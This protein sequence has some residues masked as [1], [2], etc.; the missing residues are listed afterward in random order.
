[1]NSVREEAARIK[2]QM[3]EDK[4][5]D[6]PIARGG[7]SAR[8]FSDMHRK[9][10][11]KMPSIGA[12]PRTA[13]ATYGQHHAHGA[14]NDG[15][16]AA[17]SPRKPLVMTHGNQAQ[18]TSTKSTSRKEDKGAWSATTSDDGSVRTALKRKLPAAL[19]DGDVSKRRRQDADTPQMPMSA[20]PKSRYLPSVI[21]TPTQASLARS[22]FPMKKMGSPDRAIS[23]ARV[24]SAM[25]SIL[26]RPLF[27]FSDDPHKLAAGT[28]LPLENQPLPPVPHTPVLKRVEFKAGTKIG[29]EAGTFLSSPSPSRLPTPMSKIVYPSLGT[30]LETGDFTFRANQAIQFRATPCAFGEH[31]HKRKHA[32]DAENQPVTLE[33][34]AKRSKT[35]ES[36]TRPHV[37]RST[38]L[39]PRAPSPKKTGIS[40]SR[41]NMLA[42]P[43]VRT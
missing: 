21:S 5:R 39:S 24:G 35:A 23:R 30:A 40:M 20:P 31:E 28:H 6:E 41:L 1:M 10:F 7:P 13:A 37:Q 2:F 33:P 43:K 34:S 19:D 8:R 17:I 36:P 14:H 16:S 11:S 12:L 15:R 29:D 18:V 27:K 4:A 25:K 38:G 42:R 32:E 22:K 3:V 26:H 9:Q